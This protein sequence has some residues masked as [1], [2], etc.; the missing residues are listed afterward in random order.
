M[1]PQ[2]RIIQ[3]LMGVFGEPKTI[4]PQLFLTE[5]AAAID[6]WDSHILEQTGK[7]VIRR[8]KYWPRPAE[9]IEIAEEMVAA[10]A[11]KS[12]L[13]AGID[14]AHRDW[15]TE[16]FV[17][18]NRLIRCEMGKQAAAEGWIGQLHDFCRRTRALPNDRQIRD[19]KHE[20]KLFDE[21]YR[22]CVEGR[23]G[24]LN[25]ALKRMG[26]SFI[27]KRA[28]LAQIVEGAAA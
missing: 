22:A 18:A 8:C 7:E 6:G 28:R 5:F 25:D 17:E 20:A 2:Q 12:K 16:A 26:D 14:P 9:V 27:A 11:Q 19:L 13:G 23:G 4:D 1:T 21:A 10:R 24:T 3:R 15:T